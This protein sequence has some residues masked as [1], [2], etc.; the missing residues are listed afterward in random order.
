VVI[1][2]L[3]GSRVQIGGPTA[4]FI[5][6]VFNVIDKFGYGALILCT[7]LAKIMLIAAGSLRI[8]TLLKYIPQPVITGFT[9]GIAVSIFSS[10][11][12]DL[13]GLDMGKGP[14]DFFPRWFVYRRRRLTAQ[15][16]VGLCE[17][18]KAST[19]RQS[20][21]IRISRRPAGSTGSVHTRRRKEQTH[22]S[23]AALPIRSPRSNSGV[24]RRGQRR[25]PP[26]P[27]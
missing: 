16:H 19:L 21:P 26:P 5:P 18:A 2:G 4:A 13:L 25:E 7:L 8:D 22:Q 6:V 15:S 10:Q 17:A 3:G 12:K 27:R 11:I 20:A 9:S 14:A 1:R 23:T 24:A